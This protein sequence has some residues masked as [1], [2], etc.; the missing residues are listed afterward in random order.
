MGEIVKFVRNGA[1]KVTRKT[2][3]RLHRKI[4]ALKL[5]F[6]ALDDPN[7]P[8]LAG[9]LL[10]LADLV[11]D[12]A[13]GEATDVPLVTI[14][15][16]AF[17]VIYAHQDVDLI[18]DWVPGIGHADDSAVVRAVLIEHEKV[19]ER[20]ANHLGVQWREVSLAP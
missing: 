15:A 18:P 13:E 8:H 14:A 2:L 9:Q 17:A 19:L 5:E 3:E 20:F 4:P 16:A 11:E 7:H 12:F 1:A 10:L 6:A